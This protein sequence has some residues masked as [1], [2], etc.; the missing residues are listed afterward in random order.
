MAR[1]QVMI[2][3]KETGVV[4]KIAREVYNSHCPAND[5]G[6]L[7][8]EDLY[9]CGLTGLLESKRNYDPSK[10]IPFLAFAARRIRGA[11][12]DSIRKMP[13]IRLPQEQQQKVKELEQVRCELIKTEGMADID[14]L[15]QRLGWSIHEV[16]HVMN[17]SPS[18]TPTENTDCRGDD[19][20]NGFSGTIIKDQRPTPEA[21]SLRKELTKLIQ[22]CL[23][24][25]TDRIRLVLM[26]RYFEDLRLREIAATLS[27]SAENV[28]LMQKQA[29]EDMKNCLEQNGWSGEDWLEIVS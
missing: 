19:T 3:P 20:E 21:T 15:A 12:I 16:Y 4:R 28:R 27:C 5:S 8:L 2:T 29:E 11:M 22:K 17:L 26:A 24:T 23:E 14:A 13:I 7:T 6:S 18:L 25:L 1:P 10:N 9:H